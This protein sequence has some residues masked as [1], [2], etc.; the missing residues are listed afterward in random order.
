M[1]DGSQYAASESGLE[2][3]G[4]CPM[5]LAQSEA[6]MLA[7]GAGGRVMHDLIDAVFLKAFDSPALDAKHDGAVIQFGEIKLA[8]TTD[9]YVVSPLFFPGGDIGSLAVYG[10]MNDLAMCGARPLYLSAGFILEEG[11]PMQV[12]Q[13]VVRSMA[14]AAHALEVLH[15]DP[16]GGEAARIGTVTDQPLPPVSLETV[17]GV[18]RVLDMLT[19]E[20]LPRIC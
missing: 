19:G 18:T 16:L 12:L 14:D 8:F 10:T 7:H 17:L 20:Q 13:R 9:S 3:S 2:F 1:D 15:A 11:L 4:A 5:P 6:V